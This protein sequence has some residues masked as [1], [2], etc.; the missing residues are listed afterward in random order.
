MQPEKVYSDERKKLQADELRPVEQVTL[1]PYA[2]DH[3]YVVGVSKKL[4]TTSTTLAN[5]GSL[6]S[7]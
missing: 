3:A 7:L 2:H 5:Q 4:P 6:L 1:Q